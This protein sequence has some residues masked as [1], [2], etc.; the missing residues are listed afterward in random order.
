MKINVVPLMVMDVSVAIWMAE[1]Q[2]L[3]NVCSLS[4]FMKL[5]PDDVLLQ[6]RHNVMQCMC[7]YCTDIMLKLQTLNDVATK[8]GKKDTVT[9]QYGG[10]WGKNNSKVVE[11]MPISDLLML[12]YFSILINMPFFFYST[13]YTYC[14]CFYCFIY[15]MV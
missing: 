9:V 5:R 14:N 7:E 12:C 4:V 15:S 13:F 10:V 3:N 11:I 1:S 8:C 2:N 6:C